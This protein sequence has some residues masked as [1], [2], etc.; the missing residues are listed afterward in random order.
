MDELGLQKKIPLLQVLFFNLL[1]FL[2]GFY[3]SWIEAP[4][5]YSN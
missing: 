5:L 2:C 4:D 3:V 1:I